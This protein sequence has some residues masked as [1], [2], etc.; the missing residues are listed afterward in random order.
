MPISIQS[1]L[2]H[3]ANSKDAR[4]GQDL[5]KHMIGDCFKSCTVYTDK[6]ILKIHICDSALK[7]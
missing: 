6:G 5:E 7:D 1:S 2:F 4:V 3:S